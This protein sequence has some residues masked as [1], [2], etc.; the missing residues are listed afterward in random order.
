[1]P[2]LLPLQTAQVRILMLINVVFILRDVKKTDLL[3]GSSEYFAE[4]YRKLPKMS[5]E[6]KS[7]LVLFVVATDLSS[8]RK[9]VV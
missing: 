1:M 4:Q 7:A 6:E 9:S 8:D 2:D 5:F 3:G